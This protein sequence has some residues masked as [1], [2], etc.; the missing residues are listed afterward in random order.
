MR[1]IVIMYLAAVNSRQYTIDGKVSFGHVITLL[2]GTPKSCGY[3]GGHPGPG[4]DAVSNVLKC[5]FVLFTILFQDSRI[6]SNWACIL[7]EKGD[8]MLLYIIF[9]EI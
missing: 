1:N 5:S 3:V 8:T 4:E 2:C 6:A 7:S 9:N